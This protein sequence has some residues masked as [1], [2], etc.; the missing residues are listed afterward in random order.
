[1]RARTTDNELQI[2][3]VEFQINVFLKH[4]YTLVHLLLL[5][6]TIIRGATYPVCTQKLKFLKI[7]G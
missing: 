5:Y 7:M 4:D 1:M 2:T 3:L 6:G